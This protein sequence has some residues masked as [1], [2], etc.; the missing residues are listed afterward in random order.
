MCAT[1]LHGY[2]R[3]S[4]RCGHIIC[5]DM[6]T[7]SLYLTICQAL[8]YHVLLFAVMLFL[9]S[10]FWTFGRLGWIRSGS[11]VQEAIQML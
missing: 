7:V 10:I 2:S 3:I 9:L 8:S 11:A 4:T 5:D 6:I 1:A